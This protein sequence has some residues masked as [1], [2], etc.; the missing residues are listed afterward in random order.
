[1]ENGFEIRIDEKKLAAIIAKLKN[2]KEKIP[3]AM[4]NAVN[5]TARGVQTK[6]IARASKMSGVKKSL[7]R[8]RLQLV[9]ATAGKLSAKLSIDNKPLSLLD[10]GAKQT[11]E[12]VTFKG[13]HGWVLQ[14]RAFIGKGGNEGFKKN[15]WIRQMKAGGFARL[16]ESLRSGDL[17]KRSPLQRLTGARIVPVAKGQGGFLKSLFSR[18]QQ[19]LHENME[20]HIEL[21]IKKLKKQKS[22]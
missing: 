14:R 10:S 20:R 7:I 13:L 5:D 21:A 2:A 1:M 17:V 22:K 18:S 4:R 9:R 12:G 6:I 16:G 11:P 19:K 8:N 15:V 3:G